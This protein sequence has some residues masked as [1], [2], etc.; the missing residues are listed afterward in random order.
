MKNQNLS[1]TCL[2]FPVANKVKDIFHRS[3]PVTI[4]SAF[5]CEASEL[6]GFLYP[7]SMNERKYVRG[8]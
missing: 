2:P 1:P 5:R 6:C 3:M 7:L 4:V 8:T